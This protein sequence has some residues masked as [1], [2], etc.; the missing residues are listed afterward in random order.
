MASCRVLVTART[1]SLLAIYLLSIAPAFCEVPARIRGTIATITDASL[2]VKEHHGRIFTL[3][4]GSYTTY[5][6]VLPSRLGAI[7]INDFVGTAVKGPLSSMIAVELALIPESMHAGRIQLYSWD[8]LPDPLSGHHTSTNM[9]NGSVSNVSLVAQKFTSTKMANGSVVT[10]KGGDD[11]FTLVVTYGGGSKN[12]RIVVPSNTPIV[13]Y[14]LP[15][16]SAIAVGS[17]VMIKTRQ[18][19]EAGL[20]TIGKGV[21]PPM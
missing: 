12:F 8:S 18:G 2:T 7:R 9:I 6:N 13:R 5:A 10:K 16:R 14:V 3:N 1:A 21:T 20:V 15:D 17:A 11:G 4:T 19:N